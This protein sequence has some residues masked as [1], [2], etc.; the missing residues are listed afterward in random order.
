[1]SPSLRR[2][3][4]LP[5]TSYPVARRFFLFFVALLTA[6]A[7]V[8]AQS[9]PSPGYLPPLIRITGA[10][11]EPGEQFSDSSA[12]FDVRIAEKLWTL[13]VRDV[14][15]LTSR[16]PGGVSLLRNLGGFLI[17]TGPVELVT[18]LTSEETRGQPLTIEGRLY[19]TERV[20]T[21]T[22]VELPDPVLH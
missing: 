3:L 19:M 5:V 6:V 20:L 17:I 22:A 12:T 18:H 21:L 1:M 9:P 7:P 15:S 16:V 13:R 4:L 10:L 14:E 2:A 11:F 8:F